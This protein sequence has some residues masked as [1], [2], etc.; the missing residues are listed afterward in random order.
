MRND[1]NRRR[2]SPR[3][4]LVKVIL[5]VFFLSLVTA[6][7]SSAQGGTEVSARIFKVLLLPRVWVG[8]V[9]CLIGLWLLVRSW[10]THSLRLGFLCAIFFVFGI[11]AVL[12]LG[13]FAR[14]LGI[15]PS[16]LC[17]IARPLQFVRAGRGVPVAFITILATI[18]AMSVIGNKLFC[19]WVCPLGALQEISNRAP[20]PRKMKTRLPFRASNVV[21]TAIFVV[22]LVVLVWTG[23][24]IYDRFNPFEFFHWGFGLV[25]TTAFLVTI[26]AGLFVFRPFCYLVCPIGLVTWV[27]EHVSLFRVNLE[28]SKCTECS[29]C[30]EESQCPAVPSILEE[31]KS[32]PDCHACGRCIELCPE[33][34]L[35]FR[36][37]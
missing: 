20:L 19:G 26:A 11:V 6:T 8:G 18:G 16:P 37:R 7:V 22:F 32:R 34:A 1:L 14:G 30:S 35:R 12:P 5:A 36:M 3:R 9:F 15:H 13:S 17:I 28:K 31:R 21:R 27:L 33:K 29:I 2:I 24:S 4:Q 23:R 25:A 10:V